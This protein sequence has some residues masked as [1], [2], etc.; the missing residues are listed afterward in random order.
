MGITK[1][2]IEKLEELKN[3]GLKKCNRCNKEKLLD[4]FSFRTGDKSRWKTSYCKKCMNELAVQW[5]ENNLEKFR[6][7]Q[8]KY[9]REHYGR[10]Q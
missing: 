10:K 3:R 5:R 7:Y 1:E 4:E 2:E 9:Q 6:S 8:N